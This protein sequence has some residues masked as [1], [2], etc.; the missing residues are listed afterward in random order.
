MLNVNMILFHFGVLFYLIWI[1]T[2]SFIYSAIMGLEL[3]AVSAVADDP[4]V[5]RRRRH[6]DHDG[7]AHDA[8]GLPLH[9]I[10]H[11]AR[12]SGMQT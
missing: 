3:A 5:L 7:D 2:E 9:P 4:D 1:G 6:P 10:Q 12:N 11:R 8:R